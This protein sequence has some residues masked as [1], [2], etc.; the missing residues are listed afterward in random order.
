MTGKHKEG[1]GLSETSPMLCIN[2]MSISE[3]T[4]TCGLPVPS[5]EIKLIDDEGNEVREGEAGEICARGPQI[6]KG[7]W[8]NAE[9]NKAA[10]TPTASSRPATS[11]SSSTGAS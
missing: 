3:F 1:Y 7:Y 5:T 2:P 8:N 6:M 4:E 11:A 10:F 9:A